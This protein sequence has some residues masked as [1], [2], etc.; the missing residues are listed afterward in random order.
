M[1]TRRQTSFRRDLG[2]HPNWLLL[3]VIEKYSPK[4]AYLVLFWFSRAIAEFLR[5]AL[6]R[7]QPN[8]WYRHAYKL[9][10]A[11]KIVYGVPEVLKW[12]DTH[13]WVV[14]KSP[15]DAFK[16]GQLRA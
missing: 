12:P 1:W 16:Y 10:P 11:G 4:R 13:S 15:P 6:H 8:A 14:M 9:L 5:Q 7:K 2:Y 3:E